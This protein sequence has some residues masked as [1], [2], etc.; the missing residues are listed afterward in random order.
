MLGT[1]FILTNEHV[2]F[3]QF[4][5]VD[6]NRA[7]V[8]P[9]NL[10][11]VP[12]PAKSAWIVH[13]VSFIDSPDRKHTQGL[14]EFAHAVMFPSNKMFDWRSIALVEGFPGREEKHSTPPEDAVES[15]ELC[16]G[17]SKSSFMKWS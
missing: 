17:E 2:D 1:E 10:W 13:Q 5:K 9:V 7:G 15:C 4:D 3:Q 12:S 8:P 14:N 16:A 11:R 6:T